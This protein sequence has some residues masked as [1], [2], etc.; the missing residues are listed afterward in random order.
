MI[1]LLGFF[2][3][4][5]ILGGL[6]FYLWPTRVVVVDGKI[7]RRHIWR[8]TAE[9]ALA[10]LAQINFHYQAVVGFIGVWEFVSQSGQSFTVE[11]YSNRVPK[12]LVVLEKLL[13][14]FSA[15]VFDQQFQEGDIEDT[16]EVWRAGA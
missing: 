10:E 6:V 15:S 1:E 16:L 3:L 7:V 8:T 9:I 12:G 13:P 2:V 5:G 11:T 14:N 4:V